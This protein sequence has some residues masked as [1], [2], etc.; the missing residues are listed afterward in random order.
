[1][2]MVLLIKIYKLKKAPGT[3]YTRR[4]PRNTCTC[5]V[6]FLFQSHDTGLSG[7]DY[8]CFMPFCF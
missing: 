3:G 1:M 4:S 8:E 2:S 5:F 7:L 6:S